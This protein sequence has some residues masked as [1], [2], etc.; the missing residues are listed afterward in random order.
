MKQFSLQLAVHTGQREGSVTEVFRV[1]S[2]SEDNWLEFLK[3]H[4]VKRQKYFWLKLWCLQSTD[5]LSWVLRRLGN[6][7][8]SWVKRRAT[9]KDFL[10]QTNV[11]GSCTHWESGDLLELSSS[12]PE[13][14][15]VLTK[16][17]CLPCG[18]TQIGT[19]TPCVG[20]A[21]GRSMWCWAGQ[22]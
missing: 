3:G 20:S 2:S 9:R 19:L 22:S 6:E 8:W 4:A 7:A 10:L 13:L 17:F 15:V 1:F 21:C 12:V 16:G 18:Y 14:R 11:L 5:G